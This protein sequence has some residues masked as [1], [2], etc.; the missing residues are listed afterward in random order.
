LW[1]LS[2]LF[3]L[4]SLSS[5][6]STSGDPEK[7]IPRCG[8]TFN[9]C[10]FVE[11]GSED[12]RI[13][14]QFEVAMRFSDGL[15][16]VR[17]DG[18][19]G[20]I[21]ATG[22]VVIAPRYEAAGPFSGDYA[23]VWINGRSGAIDRTGQ[24]VVPAQFD[25]LVPFASGAFIARPLRP[26]AERSSEAA[27][28][29]G[30]VRLEGLSDS[31]IGLAGGIYH[32]SKG[33]LTPQDLQFRPFDEPARGLIWAGRRNEHG[34]D[35][36]GL[37]RS[38]GTWQ[39]TPR[40]NHVQRLRETHAVVGSMP[41]YSL[42]PIERRTSMLRGAVDRDGKLVVPMEKRGLAYW[43][44]GYGYASEPAPDGKPRDYL[45]VRKG[46]VLPNGD[47]LAGQWFDEVDIREDG[48]LPRGRTGNIWHS[49]ER[50]GRLVADQLEGTAF[51]ECP[52]G[53][54]FVHRGPLVEVQPPGDGKAAG[55]FERGILR[56]VDCPG[57]FAAKRDG[58]WF[59]IL[60]DGKVLGEP[61][62]FDS[63]YDMHSGLAAVKVGDK[64]GIIDRTGAFT[65]KPT[66]RKLRPGAKGKFV[67][68]EGEQAA[69]I[70]GNGR[71]IKAPVVPKPAPAQALACEGGLRFF[72]AE[73][74]WGLQDGDGQTVVEPRY[75]ALSCFRQG[76]SW[77]AAPGGKEWCPVGP[78]GKRREAMPCRETYYPMIVTHHYPE[79][80]SDDRHESSVL[81]N[82]AWLDY[83]AGNRKDAPNWISDGEHPGSYSVIPG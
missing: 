60:E 33:W 56:Q 79:K 18:R 39:V 11:R 6:S 40:Y 41:D 30:D 37:L 61:E 83:R 22:R 25:R 44:G 12:A 58:K 20:Y 36:W 49:I 47:L 73:G 63:L 57:P 78:E 75:R 28:L 52:N 67:V 38:D 9:L 13:P 81:W 2:A 3:A 23:E 24:I 68:G 42:P 80:F 51:V 62:G 59:I 74:L 14:K 31:L 29:D 77:T 35:Q 46:I 69:W 5:A 7:W 1:K 65:V 15:A 26:G 10:G 53:L 32:L 76:V 55:R 66:F 19:F 17:I 70:D 8:G 71:W 50:D 45:E 34:D 48:K 54:K 21:D 16:A 64:W 27:R 72:S 82:R 43:R 4:I